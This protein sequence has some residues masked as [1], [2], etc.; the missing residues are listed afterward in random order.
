MIP[1]ELALILGAILV[2]SV[3]FLIWLSVKLR[4]PL[5]RDLDEAD[6][7]EAVTRVLLTEVNGG[8][9][10]LEDSR[11][12]KWFSFE[13]AAGDNKWATLALRI[14]RVELSEEAAQRL[15]AL[16]ESNGFLYE[17][18][19]DS[20]S[21]IGAKVPVPITDIWDKVSRKEG[22]KA[23][24]LLVR[25]LEIEPSTKY[26]ARLFGTPRLWAPDLGED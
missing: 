14:P 24:E 6:F 18:Q 2:I 25:F 16:M 5:G 12:G 10:R 11:T 4:F 9:I 13:R 19:P 20:L 8:G 21:S 17:P 15:K 3:A 1:F 23:A 7:S 26:K 22:A